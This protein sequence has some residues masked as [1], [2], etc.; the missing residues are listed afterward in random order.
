MSDS[1][2]GFPLDLP[3]GTPFDYVRFDPESGL[4]ARYSD[5]VGP[6]DQAFT[7]P[8][9]VFIASTAPD[10]DGDGLPDDV[11]F[12]VGSDPQGLAAPYS[13][14]SAPNDTASP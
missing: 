9:P 5:I 4:V 3:A 7:L 6:D 2:G 14:F 13:S 11:E 12:A 8:D 10:T 1:D